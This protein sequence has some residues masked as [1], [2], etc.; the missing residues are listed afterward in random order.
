MVNQVDTVSA[1]HKA[2]VRKADSQVNVI[3]FYNS[4]CDK[5]HRTGAGW[6]ESVP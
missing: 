2:L 5:G 3:T 4:L 1:F 6:C